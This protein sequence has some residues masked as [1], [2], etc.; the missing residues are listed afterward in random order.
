MLPYAY[1]KND[2]YVPG[3]LSSY[4]ELH[5]TSHFAEIKRDGVI[6][7]SLRDR[8]KGLSRKKKERKSDQKQNQTPCSRRTDKNMVLTIFV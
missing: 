1:G 6:F 5:N 4:F 2:M 3:F 8:K 7:F